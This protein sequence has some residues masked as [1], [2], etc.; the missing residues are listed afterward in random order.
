MDSSDEDD[1]WCP[2]TQVGLDDLL[3]GHSRE[4]LCSTVG[5]DSVCDSSAAAAVSNGTISDVAIDAKRSSGTGLQANLQSA[6]P[7]VQGVGSADSANVKEI[8]GKYSAAV[9]GG[10][11]G[12]FSSLANGTGRSSD[13]FSASEGYAGSAMYT[14]GGDFSGSQSNFAFAGQ[15]R[16]QASGRVEDLVHAAEEDKVEG[17]ALFQAGQYFKAYQAWKRSIDLL[18]PLDRGAL[19]EDGK[20]VFI[21]LCSNAAQALL[22]CP[23]VDGAATEMAASMADKALAVDPSN[24]RALFRRGCAY[25]NAQGW[26]LARKDFEQ[27]LSLEPGNDAARRELEKIEEELPPAAPDLLAKRQEATPLASLPQ[28]P[29]SAVKMAQKEAERFRREILAVADGKG[30]VAEWCK[31]FNKIQVLTA[32]WAKHQLKDPEI[33]QDLLL[34]RGPLF[35]AMT[36]Q[37]REDFLCA[38]DF[39]QEVRQKHQDDIN[40]L[41]S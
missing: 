41:Y 7:I 33:L 8:A 1:G 37:Q 20:R 18:E 27:V 30:S 23:E 32:D 39:V 10:R 15:L 4:V 25:A 2:R 28:D 11:A 14:Y 38:Y 12:A 40:A 13:G 22:K 3:G 16:Q 6:E 5:G 31:R 24:T 21:A 34:L 19:G 17:T 36:D 29:A 26:L 9:S 35:Q